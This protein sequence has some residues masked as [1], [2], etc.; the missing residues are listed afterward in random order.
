MFTEVTTGV[1][2]TR[3]NEETDI[4]ELLLKWNVGDERAFE[5]LI[6]L[7]YDELRRIAR[8]HL[9][10]EAQTRTLQ[11]TALVHE[12]YLKLIDQTRANWQ[13]RAQFFG[14]SANIMRRILI[15]DARK[16][17]RGKRGGGAFKISLDDGNID[18]SDERASELLA[19]DE[20]LERLAKEDPEK[21]KIVEL[22]YFGGLSIE[23]TAETLG[24]GTATVIRHWRIAKAW[25]YKEIVG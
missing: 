6:P 13:N 15:D 11:T 19:L 3:M 17:L 21:A 18:V 14:V 5:Q 24:I 25:L 1:G 4:T 8:R 22:K 2:I 12:A 10:R 16:R 20:A 7:V 23:E 9:S